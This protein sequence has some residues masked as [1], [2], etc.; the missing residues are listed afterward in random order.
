MP[1][2]LNQSNRRA[3]LD[4]EEVD[5]SMG[6]LNVAGLPLLDEDV[7]VIGHVC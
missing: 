4:N 7:D 1:F 5:A 3:V 6:D 2:M